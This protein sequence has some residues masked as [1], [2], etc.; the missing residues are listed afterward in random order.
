MRIKNIK[1]LRRDAKIKTLTETQCINK[2]AL[3]I[4][5]K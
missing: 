3:K 2:I 4:K 1:K 5:K